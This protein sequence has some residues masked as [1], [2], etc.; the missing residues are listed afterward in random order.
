MKYR[1]EDA[2][3]SHFGNKSVHEGDTELFRLKGANSEV[4][5]YNTHVDVKLNHDEEYEKMTTPRFDENQKVINP[6][7]HEAFASFKAQSEALKS[8]D[9]SADTLKKA[10]VDDTAKPDKNDLLDDSLEAT[11]KELNSK[12]DQQPADNNGGQSAGK[13][14]DEWYIKLKDMRRRLPPP[15]TVELDRMFRTGILYKDPSGEI[16]LNELRA[17]QNPHVIF[18]VDPHVVDQYESGNVLELDRTGQGAR[19]LIDKH[20]YL[21]QQ[22]NFTAQRIEK[23]IA[24]GF[25]D[26]A[27]TAEARE[28]QQK[29][30]KDYY[31]WQTKQANEL[32]KTSIFSQVK[33]T[34]PHLQ[35]QQF[36]D[37]R[38][39]DL[40]NNGVKF[41]SIRDG[42]V[43]TRRPT[44]S[45]IDAL[46]TRHDVFSNV[47][48]QPSNQNHPKFSLP[49]Q[50]QQFF[51]PRQ[52]QVPQ[53]PH[54]QQPHPQQQ[55]QQFQPPH[56]A[57]AKKKS[58]SSLF[59]QAPLARHHSQSDESFEQMY[60][61]KS[62]FEE[63][64][65]KKV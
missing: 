25:F 13:A 47:S 22:R 41:R 12:G 29:K 43:V 14:I 30:A 40:Q 56:Q 16:Q 48:K 1:V 35:F 34:D 15:T 27:I 45:E 60:G 59:A 36:T 38:R 51:R 63:I 54:S 28:E 37:Q 50:P 17:N 61:Q 23:Q 10:G 57:P 18:G 20:E 24:A 11:I 9:V 53:P 65:G 21:A 55:S 62:R 31:D 58:I 26:L 4:F 3:M 6:A 7:S 8:G 39:E 42:S 64:Y 2:L 5:D 52:T 19:Q 44:G 49:D 46:D 33:Y 32:S